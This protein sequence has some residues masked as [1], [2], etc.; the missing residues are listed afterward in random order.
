MAA[1]KKPS[2]L[3]VTSYQVGFGD[4]YL[5]S[6]HYPDKKRHVLM[7]FGT[8]FRSRVKFKVDMKAV[9]D[10]IKRDCGGELAMVVATHRH[11]D[12]ISGFETKK[13]GSGPGDVIR[14]CKPRL[15]LQPW[16]EDPTLP[17]SATSPKAAKTH[18]NALVAMNAL[19]DALTHERRSLAGLDTRETFAAAQELGYL[20]G[21]NITNR[22]AVENLMTMAGKDRRNY[23][24][25]SLNSKLDVSALL[26]GVEIQVLG[27]PTLDQSAD[28]KNYAQRSDDYW[29]LQA[30]AAAPISAPAGSG[31]L[32][33]GGTRNGPTSVQWFVRRLKLMR[34]DS[35]FQIVRSL[36]GVMNNTSLILLF[37]IGTKRLLFPGD[38]QL[39]NWSAA[40]KDP[41]IRALLA[42][43]DLYKV[44]H[45]GS[46]NATPKENLWKKFRKRGK[47]SFQTLLST[48]A[49]EYNDVPLTNFVETLKKESRLLS[50]ASYAEAEPSK[51]VTVDF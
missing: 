29:K 38:A 6:F 9:A 27:P 5:L 17:K 32:F 2:K 12:H 4:C 24:Y 36:D 45:H 19:A 22:S 40:L 44:G 21:D 25:L 23:K 28:I 48:H 31:P 18:V 15:V 34:A 51:S 7:D 13:N 8:K 30:L 43:V 46:L 39:E 35:L 42:D 3:T 41:K 50:T 49:G 14:S 26:P 33:K 11:Y 37:K 47:P 10:R 20:G 1:A 16:T